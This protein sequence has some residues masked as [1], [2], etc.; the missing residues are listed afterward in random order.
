MLCSYCQ[1]EE[2]KFTLK[3]GK[4]CC[5]PNY[6]SCPG[7]KS[8]ISEKITVKLKEQYANGVR[9]SHFKKLNDGSIWKGRHHTHETKKLLSDKIAGRQMLSTFC[10]QRSEEM[11]SRYA[12]GWE[13][14]AGRTVKL[15]YFSLIAGTVKLDG[16]WELAVAKFLDSHNIKWTR[17]KKR[18]DYIDPT[19]KN[20]TYCPD[21][22]LLETN[23]FIEVK[24]YI[25]ELDRSKWSQFAGN[26]EIWD[27]AVLIAKHIIW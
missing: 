16:S 2:A 17:N 6:Q 22:Y 26:L 18:F 20:R 23:T 21:F 15:D 10:E 19:G 4:V 8:K 7:V 14:K 27:K 5:M 11:K 3:N 9:T 13:S 25:T 24:G 12:N 1:I